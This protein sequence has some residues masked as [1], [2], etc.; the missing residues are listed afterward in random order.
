MLNHALPI[1]LD[2]DNYMLWRTQME[3]VIYANDI[4]DHVEGLTVYPSKTISNGEIN[5]EFILWIRFDRMILSW[6]YSSLTPEIMGQIIGYQTSYEAWFA[7]EK[8]FSASSKAWV[9]QLR[10]EF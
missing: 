7:L 1:K 2:K 6:I 4:E 3:N 10:L 8:I 9:M 5:P